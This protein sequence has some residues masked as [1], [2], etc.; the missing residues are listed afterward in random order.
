MLHSTLRVCNLCITRVVF[1]VT[2]KCVQCKRAFY[3]NVTILDNCY[4]IAGGK[5]GVFFDAT[6]GF[7][8]HVTR[9]SSQRPFFSSVYDIRDAVRGSGLFGENTLKDSQIYS[10]I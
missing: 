6:I 10:C 4:E 5:N 3:K 8:Q 7:K 1:F 9:S 2:Q